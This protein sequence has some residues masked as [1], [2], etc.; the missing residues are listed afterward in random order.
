MFGAVGDVHVEVVLSKAACCLV[1]GGFLVGCHDCCDW[2][3]APTKETVRESGQTLPSLSSAHR[4]AGSLQ[5]KFSSALVELRRGWG[6]REKVEMK[7]S[8]PN[9]MLPRNA[10]HG[11]VGLGS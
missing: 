7:V 3:F 2:A 9:F 4:I 6:L 1:E 11:R 10:G 5:T 8:F